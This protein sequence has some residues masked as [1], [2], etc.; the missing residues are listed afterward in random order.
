MRILLWSLAGVVLLAAAI[1]LLGFLLP[2]AREGSARITI[3]APPDR[4][5]A[6]LQDVEAQPEWRA[7]IAAVFRTEGGW[8]ETTTRGEKISFAVDEMTPAR[9]RLRF[10]S[11]AGYVGSWQATLTPLARGT[12]IDVI[13]RAEIASPLGR[14]LA[15][16]FFD[17]E[18]FAI[19]YLQALK[20]RSEG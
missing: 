19:A 1:I 8:S 5:L 3:A 7:G 12:Q 20:A 18:G 9:V 15:R 11:S 14:I 16:V 17:P 13:E 6:I 10:T 2:K 4:V